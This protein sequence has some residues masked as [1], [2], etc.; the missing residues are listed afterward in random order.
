MSPPPE[1]QGG[2]ATTTPEL[3][4]EAVLGRLALAVPT[5]TPSSALGRHPGER[6]PQARQEGSSGAPLR[7]CTAGGEKSQPRPVVNIRGPSNDYQLCEGAR[8]GGRPCFRG[9]DGLRSAWVGTGQEG[10]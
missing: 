6:P 7:I 10:M 1:S 3:T 4:T 5:P 9:W 2:L 8:W